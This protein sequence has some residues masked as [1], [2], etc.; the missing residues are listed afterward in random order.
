MARV[1]FRQGI[2]T[3]P[4]NPTS[5]DQLFL[6]RNGTS[7]DLNVVNQDLVTVAFI[8]GDADYLYTEA[9]SIEAA[10]T[11]IS[12]TS[13]SWLY[14]EISLSVGEISRKSTLLEPIES[15]NKPSNASVGQLWFNTTTRKWGEFNGSTFREVVVVFAAKLASGVT[16][17]S[18]S[19]DSPLFTGTQ[20]GITSNTAIGSL[21]YNNNGKAIKSGNGNEFFTTEDKFLTGVPTGASLRINNTVISGEAICPIP[22]FSVIQYNDYN[23]VC[24][25]NP[26]ILGERLF[27]IVDEP[28]EPKEVATFITE[29]LI[30]NELWD[31]E[32]EGADINDPIFIN[33]TGELT[34]INLFPHRPPVASVVGK[35]VIYFAPRLFPQLSLLT[36]AGDGTGV[37]DAQ[38]AR[39]SEVETAS[40]TNAANINTIS[41]DLST[42][43]VNNGD[44]TIVGKLETDNTA[45]TDS[46]NTLTTKSYI[47]DLYRGYQAAFDNNAWTGLDEK[48]FIIPQTEHL[49]PP[50]TMY[51]VTIF[52]ASGKRMGVEYAV[53][54][55]NGNVTV[56]TSGAIFDGIIRI[57]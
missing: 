35:Q 13:T 20:V 54:V 28:I 14:W 37:T 55:E 47:D 23:S 15:P 40:Q 7:V 4:I 16:F 25:A 41:N 26:A 22:A 11:D 51:D 38:L 50:T 42:F 27:G 33:A 49:R 3:H 52:N 48:T 46:S 17:E 57:K 36:D 8:H 43:V 32:A 9:K 19:M 12:T 53:D 24:L 56:R 6:T 29:G 45:V 1:N 39:L 2:L 34:L 30:Y 5:G 31:W 10:W 44:T 18:M 21:V